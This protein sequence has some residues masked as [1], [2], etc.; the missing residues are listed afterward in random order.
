MQQQL[1]ALGPPPYL[2]LTWRAGTAPERQRGSGW[3]LHKAIP[4][5]PL[6][7]VLRQVDATWI[8]LQRHPEPG[9]IGRLADLAGK[10]LHDLTALN[11]DLESMLA[12]LA[13]IDDYAGVS[14]TNMHLRAAAGRAAKVLV[15]Q[16]PE[17]RWM[18]AG[19]KSPWFPGFRIYR[20][21]FD[22]NWGNA[23]DRLATDLLIGKNARE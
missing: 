14:N 10:P 17:W 19:G 8:A 21:E 2:G 18:A 7:A 3:S 13:L 12:L 22:G 5:D 1:A 16:P 23:F 4:L 6:G 11:D 20:Q 15:P 9:E